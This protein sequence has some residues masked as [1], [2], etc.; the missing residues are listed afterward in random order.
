VRPASYLDLLEEIASAD[1]FVGNDS[2]PGHLAASI[3]VPT[4]SIFGSSP[5]NWKP[6]GPRTTVVSD[7]SLEAISVDRVAAAVLRA[8]ESAEKVDA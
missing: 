7:T 5:E 1:A 2:G 4:I 3:G 6:L 8:I